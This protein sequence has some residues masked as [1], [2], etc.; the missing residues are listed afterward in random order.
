[1]ECIFLSGIVNIF[2]GLLSSAQATGLGYKVVAQPTKSE[3]V[4]RLVLR[5]EAQHFLDDTTLE[6]IVN[7]IAGF[8]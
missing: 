4:S 2:V 8:E 5:Y 7:T 1:M 3:L 6:E